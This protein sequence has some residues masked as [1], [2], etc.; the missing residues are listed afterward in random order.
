[1]DNAASFGYWVRRW[2]KAL[3][4][5]Q[6]Q[7][8]KQVACAVV[9]IKKIEMDERRPS[10]QMAERLAS[11]LDISEAQRA[12][13]IQVAIGEKPAY[14]LYLP[15]EPATTPIEPTK[16]NSL[17]VSLT[18]LIGRRAEIDAIKVCLQREDVRLVTLTG[19]GGVGKTRL[20]LQTAE[21]VQ[22]V[23][24]DGVFFVPLA[25]VTQFQHLPFVIAQNIG[26]R[27]PEKSTLQDLAA[28]F[29]QRRTLLVLDNFEHLL[30]AAPLVS[31]LLASTHFLKV[32]V[33]SRIQLHLYGERRFIIQP[34]DLPDANATLDKL[35]QNDAVTLFLDRAQ[36]TQS[37]FHLTRDNASCVAQI[38]SRLDGLPLA[39]ELAAARIDVLSPQDLL[40]RLSLRLPILTDGPH[41]MPQRQQTLRDAIAWSYD[42]L[43]L[44]EKALFERLSVFRGGAALESIESVCPEMETSTTIAALST[45]VDQSLIQRYEINGE[46]RFT[47]LETIREFAAE[48]LA[49]ADA[50]H[51][52]HLSYYLTLAQH[53]EPELTGKEE[54]TW[55]DRLEVELDNIRASLDWGLGEDITSEIR[56]SAVLLVGT[57]WLF[58]YL[59]GRW[60]EGRGWCN[61]AL[62]Y[63][64]ARNRVRAKTLTGATTLCFAQDDYDEANRYAGEAVPLWRRLGDQRGL[65]DTLQI[66]G[67]VK[68]A[69]REYATA[70]DYFA[71]GITLY[72]ALEDEHNVNALI[73][74][75]GIVAYF[76]GEHETARAYLE[77]SLAWYR[78]H[79]M[80][81]GLGSVLRWL[82]DVERLTGHYEQ[83]AR[84]Y[85]EALQ[86]NTE[87]GLPLAVAV[88]LHRLGQIALLEG[89]LI[90]ARELF[91]DSLKVHRKEGGKQGMV[92]CIVGL[93]GTAVVMGRLEIAAQL[94]GV[95]EGA[96]ESFHTMLGPADRLVW[97]Y[98]ENDL[99]TMHPQDA[100]EHAWELGKTTAL[101]RLLDE[102]M[103][104]VSD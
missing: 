15:E 14:V 64:P 41:D 80:K 60:Q 2:R 66:A 70:S 103:T 87:V 16:P 57:L 27:I 9:T 53:A 56:E 94:F 38:C 13:F 19:A 61:R 83:A 34:F 71:E 51:R 1:M 69:C 88:T 82:G 92:E 29:A 37:G 45:L 84:N 23:C 85:R 36:A 28:H 33:T 62:A 59:R 97:E 22:G 67:F 40:E 10:Q 78:L 81:D 72:K 93:A 58:W 68:L 98:Y 20:A 12:I 74:G 32:L 55:L 24:K 90:E 101:D 39:L 95:A 48:R 31:E 100:L 6:K 96:L 4:L 99:R 43:T 44:N 8:A 79:Q 26:V 104:V 7:L 65:A 25:S 89:R 35:A 30:A 47:M 76:M 42:L 102:M 46:L 3:D 75:M 21:E 86:L 77:K 63:A 50:T 49:D 73:E 17:P 5:T 52:R 54:G 18:R 91:L 11:C